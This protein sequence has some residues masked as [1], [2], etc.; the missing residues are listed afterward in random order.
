M[1]PKL[2]I[3]QDREIETRS[4]LCAA[5]AVIRFEINKWRLESRFLVLGTTMLAVVGFLHSRLDDTDI[6]TVVITPSYPAWVTRW[7]FR[8]NLW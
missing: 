6:L 2:D 8:S 1:R 4:G 5:A 7:L 3:L